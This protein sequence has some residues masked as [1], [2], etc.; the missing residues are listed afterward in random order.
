M[1][2]ILLFRLIFSI[3]F[4]VEGFYPLHEPKQGKGD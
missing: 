4:G 1:I 3:C 2:A